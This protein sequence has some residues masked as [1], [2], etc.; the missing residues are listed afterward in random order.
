MPKIAELFETMDY[1]PAPEAADPAH[2]WIAGHDA[3][4][5]HF[6]DGAWTPP[7]DTFVSQNPSNEQTLA[8]ITNGTPAD[9]EA[10]VVAA[11]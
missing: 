3:T 2:A 6:I 8:H 7:G 10:A 1:G 9:V 11:R 4:F 5:G